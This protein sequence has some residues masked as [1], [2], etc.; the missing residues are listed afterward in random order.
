MVPERI[1]DLG[2]GI[3]KIDKF[4]P[5][6][7]FSEIQ[8]VLFSDSFPWYYR[9]VVVNEQDSNSEQDFF[10][11]AHRFFFDHEPLS[12]YY[13]LI[14]PVL[15]NLGASSILSARASLLTKRDSNIETQMHT[16][17]AIG[18]HRTCVLYMNDCNGY[19]AFE[20]NGL[21]VLSKANTLVDFDNMQRHCGAYQTDAK[22]RI[23]LNINYFPTVM[24]ANGD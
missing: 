11:F 10:Q 23:V 7:L 8:A 1:V 9:S 20:K 17:F 22:V 3:L 12:E 16:D 13:E 15:R 2:D 21:K 4:L 24:G 19:T 6:G 14:K 18:N 5:D